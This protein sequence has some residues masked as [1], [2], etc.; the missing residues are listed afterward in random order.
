MRRIPLWGLGLSLLLVPALPGR[1]LAK[2]PAAAKG[3][4]ASASQLARDV[5]IQDQPQ[6]PKVL[7]Q[8]RARQS[9]TLLKFGGP[10]GAW[11]KVQVEG[12]TGWIPR[13]ALQGGGSA[14]AAPAT[15]PAVMPAAPVVKQAEEPKRA[16]LPTSPGG[17]EG[18][19]LAPLGNVGDARG[20]ATSCT[21][22][23]LFP[24]MPELSA[25][26]RE[27]LAICPANPGAQ[28]GR[29]DVAR[30]IGAHL[31]DDRVKTALSQAGRSGNR[32]ANIEWLTG[33]WVGSGPRNAFTH[34]FCGDDWNT[35]KLGGLHFLP[36]YAQLESEGK[37]CF[38]RAI[39]RSGPIAGGQ[40]LISFHG[41]APWSCATKKVGGFPVEHDAVGLL[42]LATRAFTNCCL[43]DGEKREG[44][45]FAA[46][47]VGGPA[48]RIWC[49]ARNGTY[50]IASLYPTDERPTCGSR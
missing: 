48:W 18:P 30:F 8:G 42:A 25:T 26:D 28:V 29:N 39:K 49:N 24:R 38:D 15:K 33:L 41:V 20:C 32:E 3:A 5:P 7:A 9:A 19:A 44:G 23:R 37:L 6:G 12:V 35:G 1:A 16:T 31:D 36:R 2:G 14:E 11:A 47:D 10:S 45:V 4:E 17:A 27:V 46:G 50:G 40:Y 13:D 43:R 34:V 21:G 22:E